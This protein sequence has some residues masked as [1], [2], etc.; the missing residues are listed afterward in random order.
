MTTFRARPEA[1][2]VSVEVIS[3][4]LARQYSPLERAHLAFAAAA[5]LLRAGA[6]R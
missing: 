4:D 1:M 6:D 2:G 5:P 3:E